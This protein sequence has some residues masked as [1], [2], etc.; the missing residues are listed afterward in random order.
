[1]NTKNKNIIN[2]YDDIANI[3]DDLFV[4]EIDQGIERS[5]IDMCAIWNFDSVLDIGCGT[6]ILFDH[7]TLHNYQGVDSSKL[8]LDAFY[9]KH[10]GSHFNACLTSFELFSTPKKYD[11][12]VSLFGAFSYIHPKYLH[13]VKSFLSSTGE[14]FIMVYR[15][16]YK[17]VTYE[18]AGVEFE[19]YNEDDYMEVVKEVG[20]DTFYHGD[21]MVIRIAK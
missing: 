12:V 9:E 6:G 13:K 21:Y 8:M 20:A 10:S 7:L 1:M 11:K 3:Y 5:V 4:G 2:H 18:R 17:P 19:H 14:A 15:Q 16:S